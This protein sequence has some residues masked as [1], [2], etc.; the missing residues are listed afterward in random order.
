LQNGLLSMNIASPDSG[1][2][3]F[4][5][6]VSAQSRFRQDSMLIEGNTPLEYLYRDTKGKSKPTTL[7]LDK[8]PVDILAGSVPG[9]AG[10][11][12]RDG[13]IWK[14]LPGIVTQRRAVTAQP[15]AVKAEPDAAGENKKEKRK[16]D[17]VNEKYTTST[18]RSGHKQIIDLE[19]EPHS[20]PS[21]SVVDYVREHMLDLQFQGGQLVNRKRLSL[22]GGKFWPVILYLNENVIDITNLRNIRTGDVALIKF[23][24]AGFLAGANESGGAV[25]IYTKR[26]AGS[27]NI[28]D[29]NKGQI[30]YQGYALRKK[31]P[32]PDYALVKP[33]APDTRTTLHWDGNIV[34]NSD[35]RK[36]KFVF[37]NN[38]RTKRYRV[39][40]EG[41]DVNGKLIHAETV[42]E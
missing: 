19:T 3:Y 30:T 9:S 41:I 42:V 5:F 12:Q 20:N 13:M 27:N 22:W 2:Q 17:V 4:E 8:D 34:L 24:D 21:V 33:A 36:I 35:D 18:F 10:L 31:F 29:P 39:V 28:D 15:A 14:K 32:A 23:F 40:V 37:Y 38:D 6:P 16:R 26:E 11:V 7:Q 25:A 1:T